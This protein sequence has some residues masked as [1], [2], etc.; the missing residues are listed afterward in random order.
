MSPS[1]PCLSSPGLVF[2]HISHNALHLLVM[3]TL[4]VVGQLSVH[5]EDFIWEEGCHTSAR[6]HS[7][8]LRVWLSCLSLVK[9]GLHCIGVHFVQNPISLLDRHNHPMCVS[10]L[11]T[12]LLFRSSLSIHHT[13]RALVKIRWS[14]VGLKE[15]TMSRSI[16]KSTPSVIRNNNVWQFEWGWKKTFGS[17]RTRQCRKLQE[18]VCD[19]DSSYNLN[20]NI[21][22]CCQMIKKTSKQR[23]WWWRELKIRR[24]SVDKKKYFLGFFVA[25]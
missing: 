15:P 14:S 23:G 12:L 22:L 5:S 24:W 7:A 1:A 2:F 9:S 21:F 19:W 10:E 4:F 13:I 6:D 8:T 11:P 20:C 18:S 3:V 17:S 25:T 16:I